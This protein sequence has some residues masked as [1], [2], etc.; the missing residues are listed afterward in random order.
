[1]Y[2]LHECVCV[3]IRTCVCTYVCTYVQLYIKYM[4]VYLYMTSYGVNNRFCWEYASVGWGFWLHLTP[5]GQYTS[6]NYH[7]KQSFSICSGKKI[8]T[9][10]QEYMYNI[11]VNST[12]KARTR[13]RLGAFLS[14]KQRDHIHVYDLHKPTSYNLR[15]DMFYIL[16]LPS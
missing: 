9:I 12:C 1:M 8:S 7:F 5:G 16:G 13:R 3:C 2:M 4:Y 10:K 14:K 6:C 11:A 15:N